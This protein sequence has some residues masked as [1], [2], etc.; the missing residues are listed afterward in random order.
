[1]D[2]RGG[3]HIIRLRTHAMFNNRFTET[4]IIAHS[5]ERYPA[6][7]VQGLGVTEFIS[8][9]DLPGSGFEAVDAA[10]RRYVPDVPSRQGKLAIYNPSRP[11]SLVR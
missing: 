7:Y 10:V 11:G 6:D 2:A 5:V 4:P 9:P 8:F 1:M 3:D